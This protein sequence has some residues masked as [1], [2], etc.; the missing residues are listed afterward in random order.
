MSFIVEIGRILNHLLKFDNL[1]HRCWCDDTLLWGFEEREQLMGFMNVP[2]GPRPVCV[3]H[4]FGRAGCIKIC[5]DGLL[6]EISQWTAKFPS[7][8]NDLK[9][10][11]IDNRIFKQ[12]NRR[13]WRDQRGRTRLILA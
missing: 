1:C 10:L 3:V 13:Y 4:I 7:F 5:P 6:E 11:L 2:A 9:M 8:I 12:R